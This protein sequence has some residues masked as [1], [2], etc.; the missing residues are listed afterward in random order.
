MHCEGKYYSTK[1]TGTEKHVNQTLI[2]SYK[3]KNI[4]EY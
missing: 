4:N 1:N 2:L 3:G